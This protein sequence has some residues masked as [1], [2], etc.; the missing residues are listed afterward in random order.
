MDNLDL[1]NPSALIGHVVAGISNQQDHSSIEAEEY[2]Q[3]GVS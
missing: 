1:N 2:Q 3:H